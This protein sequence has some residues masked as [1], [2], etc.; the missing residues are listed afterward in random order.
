M[1]D[2]FAGFRRLWS[3]IWGKTN[4]PH[5][6]AVSSSVLAALLAVGVVLGFVATR[7][8]NHPAN[9]AFSSTTTTTAPSTTTAPPTTAAPT[10]TTTAKPTTTTTAAHVAN[11]SSPCTLSD[12][13]ISVSTGG[14]SSAVTISTAITDVVACAFTPQAGGS[15]SC[16]VFVDVTDAGGNQVWPGAKQP[17]SCSPPNAV[18]FSPGQQE[19]VSVVWNQAQRGSYTANGFWSWSSGGATPQQGS[20][21][22]PFSVG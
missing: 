5:R 18:A 12:V 16:P 20:A 14:S 8:S 2:R 6:P 13:R 11:A 17:E 4:H 1:T 9:G 21:S 19:T 22:A 15:L 7:S 3:S 10:T